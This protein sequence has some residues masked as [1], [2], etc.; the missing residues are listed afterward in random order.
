[1]FRYEST[2]KN[3]EKDKKNSI[4][5]DDFEKLYELLKKKGK[6]ENERKLCNDEYQNIWENIGDIIFKKESINKSEII[7]FSKGKIDVTKNKVLGNDYINLEIKDNMSLELIFKIVRYKEASNFINSYDNDYDNYLNE[8]EEP[9]IIKAIINEIQNLEKLLLNID[10]KPE[11]SVIKK[12]IQLYL[13]IIYMIL[14]NYPFYISKR[15][16]LEKYYLQL[17]KYK[18]WP[19]QI[20]VQG[21]RIYKLLINELYLPGITIFKEIRKKYCLDIIDPNKFMLIS[22]DFLRY[23]FFNDDR[24]NSSS[25]KFIKDDISDEKFNINAKEIFS[26]ASK[27]FNVKEYKPKVDAKSLKEFNYLTIMH[28]IIF[29]CQQIL[30]YKDKIKSSIYCRLCEQYFKAIPDY[31]NRDGYIDL[32]GKKKSEDKKESINNSFDKNVSRNTLNKS[33]LNSFLNILDVGLKTDYYKD[34]LPM[35]KEL[36]KKIMGSINVQEGQHGIELLNLRKFLIPKVEIKS[37]KGLSLIYLYQCNYINIED[38]Y[39]S[40]LKKTIDYKDYDINP[41]DKQRVDQFNCIVNIKKNILENYLKMRF[42]LHEE[43]L[44]SFINILLND[45]EE[46]RDK[47]L[48]REYN[49]RKKLEEQK[50][51]EKEQKEKKL[52]QETEKKFKKKRDETQIEKEKK[53]KEHE[54]KLKSMSFYDL[55][56]LLENNPND[57]EAQNAIQKRESDSLPDIVD[58][59]DSIV[60]YILPNDMFEQHLSDYICRNNFI[61]K[62]IF[63]K[64]SG[65]D[66]NIINRLLKENLCI[67]LE[68]ANNYLELDVYK[69]VLTPS[70]VNEKLIINYF[71][72]FIEIEFIDENPPLSIT[73]LN[74]SEN[75]EYEKS[76]S[77]LS[78]IKKIYIMNLMFKEKGKKET[79]SG[80]KYIINE[81]S[82]LLTVFCMKNLVN[83]INNFSYYGKLMA[84]Q[85]NSEIFNCDEI[86]IT[87]EFKINGIPDIEENS[88]FKELIIGHATYDLGNQE[89]RRVKLKI[90]IF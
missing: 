25:Y 48:E 63:S 69:I 60:L 64:K 52:K 73:Y 70:K 36:E 90:A 32:V 34:F 80:A 76:V 78:E 42:I 43:Q 61:Y 85:T 12:K 8:E 88:T 31:K 45:V 22:D 33:L 71:Y 6:E 84:H 27:L 55:K 81:N 50:E 77:K 39:L 13:F 46:L 57:I 30:G 37:T 3:N 49:E 51:K 28:L 29:F 44:I 26:P 9:P 20:G 35:I 41:E 54:E 15:I 19:D 40:H 53:K 5:I 10:K 89:E 62:Y 47:L 56:K 68:E 17:K 16:Y 79:L 86:K 75:P 14:K 65:M 18:D 7:D 59:I 2:N 24:S 82:G 11:K 23:Y 87:G 1:M 4:D 83:E 72:S 66:Y 21:K 67:Y 38:K 74:N 58:F